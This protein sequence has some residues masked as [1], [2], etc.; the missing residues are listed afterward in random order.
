MFLIGML[1]TGHR[2]R[3][4]FYNIGR[5]MRTEYSKCRN[6]HWVSEVDVRMPELKVAV[7]RWIACCWYFRMMTGS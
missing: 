7:I 1:M 2:G 6:E 3:C 4:K 5:L